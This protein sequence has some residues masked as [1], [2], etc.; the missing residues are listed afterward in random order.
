[1][2]IK[3]RR[4]IV[5][6]SV[7]LLILAGLVYGFR[8]QP[9]PID[10][11]VVKRAPLQVAVTEEG[12]TQV[13]DRF[14][15]PAPVAG[16]AQRIELSVGDSV[17]RGQRLLSIEPLSPA[18]LNPRERAQAQARVAA[19]EAALQAARARA[20][21]AASEAELA[22]REAERITKL[23][24]TECASR[25]EQDQAV[26]RAQTARANQRSAEFAVKVARYDLDAARTALTHTA[27]GQ[28]GQPGELVPVVSPI[29]GRVLKIMH[30]SEGAVVPGTAL[31]ELGNPRSLEVVTDVLSEDA[32]R[33]HPGTPVIYGRWG[34]GELRGVVTR[35]EPVAFTKVSALGVEEQRVRVL[36]D[37]T[38]APAQWQSLG[39]GYRVESRFVLWQG[40]DVLQVPASAVFRRGDGWAVFAVRDGR[41]KLQVVKLGQ[42]NGL[43]AEV[44]DGLKEGERI[45]MHPDDTIHDGVRVAAR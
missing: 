37:I 8:P 23:C 11:A 34:G 33:I 2:H 42:R 3:W 31:L 35:V 25:Q 39:D 43:A 29:D 1:M 10:I 30:E 28:K 17:K 16:V 38:S 19:A 20:Q 4:R 40:N 6:G 13:I 26:A 41:A 32:V 7:G 45:V 18:V 36:S 9:V 15:V 22:I 44:R 5:L 24:K 27:S 21:A 14:V 12:K